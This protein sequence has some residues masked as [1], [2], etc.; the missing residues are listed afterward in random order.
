[1]RIVQNFK[2]LERS[3]RLAA[4]NRLSFKNI[5]NMGSPVSQSIP[6]TENVPSEPANTIYTIAG[7]PLETI[8]GG[9]TYITTIS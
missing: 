3:K 1:M 9:Y 4:K 2:D 5:L 6:S 7:D 8:A